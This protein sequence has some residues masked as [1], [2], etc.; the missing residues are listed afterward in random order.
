MINLHEKL[1]VMI[2]TPRTHLGNLWKEINRKEGKSQTVLTLIFSFYLPGLK[3]V[4]LPLI[5][6]RSLNL[7]IGHYVKCDLDIFPEISSTCPF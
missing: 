4:I 2:E 1:N 3:D 6:L 5:L 7:V